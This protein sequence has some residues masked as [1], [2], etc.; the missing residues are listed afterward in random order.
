MD[1]VIVNLDS[2]ER[3]A[4]IVSVIVT[5]IVTLIIISVCPEG[6]WGPNCV[7]HCLCMHE[8][9]CD[10]LN[11]QCKCTAGWTGPACEFCMFF[12]F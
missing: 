11:G 8:A 1:F 7:Q 6:M 12:F 3:D 5:T 9:D 10:P 2:W 4:L